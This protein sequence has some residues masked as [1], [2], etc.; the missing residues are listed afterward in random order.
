V[1]ASRNQIVDLSIVT[2]AF[3]VQAFAQRPNAGV[4]LA[5]PPRTAEQQQE[6]AEHGRYLAT[7][8]A[9]A[10]CHTPPEVPHQRPGATDMAGIDTDRKFR[11]DPDWF[12]YLDPENRNFLAGG[13]PF[14]LRF[15]GESNGLV[16]TLNVTPD[17]QTG[18]E[19]CIEG[20]PLTTSCWTEDELVEVIRSG[21]RKAGS[22]PPLLYLFPPHTFYRNLAEEDA[23]A[24][25]VFLRSIPPIK[26]DYLKNQ[27]VNRRLPV[28]QTP[29]Q[30]AT[31]TNL[32]VAPSGRSLTR[33][34]YLMNSLV[35]CRECHSYQKFT[36]QGPVVQQFVGGD[37]SDPF[38]GVFRLGPD[39]PLRVDEKGYSLFPYPG[40]AVLYAPNLTRFGL[41]G[42]LGYVSRERLVRSIREGLSPDKDDYGRD[43]PL[44]HVML[45]QFY[46]SMTDEDAYSIADYIKT[47]QYVPHTVEPR[48]ILFGTDWEAAFRK[49]FGSFNAMTGGTA[50][51]ITDQ[52][53]Q[54]LGKTDRNKK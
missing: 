37:P 40:Y 17:P 51:M 3:A 7:I 8:G 22:N 35:G 18:I 20:K 6:L 41:G 28:E 46:S 44:Q 16:L 14:N 34:M 2:V 39:L 47:L 12:R 52:D 4:R 30:P 24:L 15:T 25:A 1:F 38:L 45:W 26:N 9:C 32:K 31:V 27:L 43:E 29:K 48:L 50:D 49:V 53:R 36:A 11:T 21:K 13:V 42:D 33:A 23:R 19:P 10:A 54:L 5:Q